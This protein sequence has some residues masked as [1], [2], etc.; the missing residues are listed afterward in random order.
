MSR[1]QRPCQ[2]PR[3]RQLKHMPGMSLELTWKTSTRRQIPGRSGRT[4]V[5]LLLV[6]R[7]PSKGFALPNL[8][9]SV[10]ILA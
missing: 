2:L 9:Q 6:P 4:L 8:V 5:Y 3:R 10:V 7:T 1:L